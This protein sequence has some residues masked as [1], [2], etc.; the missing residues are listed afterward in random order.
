MVKG[1]LG[2]I[3][4]VSFVRNGLAINQLF[5]SEMRCEDDFASICI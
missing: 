4:L 5:V 3:I 1:D 2:T